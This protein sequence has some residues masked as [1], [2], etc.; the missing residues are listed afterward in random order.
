MSIGVRITLSHEL[1]IESLLDTL[2]STDSTIDRLDIDVGSSSCETFAKRRSISRFLQRFGFEPDPVSPSS[3]DLTF[4]RLKEPRWS[5]V[6]TKSLGMDGFSSLFERV[7]HHSISRPFST[8]KY[9][10]IPFFS[11]GAKKNGVLIAHY[12]GISRRVAVKG[13]YQQALQVADVM[14]D[15]SE[16]AVFSKEG[17]FFQVASAFLDLN[18]GLRSSHQLAYGFPNR[19]HMRLAEHL[20]LYGQVDSI[21]EC[22]W[23]PRSHKLP[24]LFTTEVITHSNIHHH[25]LDRLWGKM[26]ASYQDSILVVRD[27]EYIQTRYLNHP[28]HAYT[29]I[30]IRYRWSSHLVGLVVLRERDDDLLM[31]DILAPIHAFDCLLNLSRS[32]AF[33]LGKKQLVAWFTQSHRGR[34]FP[35]PE[36]IQDPDI[37]IPAN[38]WSEGPQIDSLQGKWWLMMGDTDFL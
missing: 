18:F 5:L 27:K 2:H 4:Q 7:F 34:L 33:D 20:G 30:G 22:L 38:V 28:E 11:L 24:W 35:Q 17:V 9:G 1:D 26:I 31:I 32:Y 8:W 21:E 15:P 10:E 6:S 12:G 36:H 13:T 37:A 14:V 23:M 19:R 25:S 3:N 29:L 16:R